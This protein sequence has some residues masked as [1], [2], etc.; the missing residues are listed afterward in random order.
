VSDQAVRVCR[1]GCN[2]APAIALVLQA[3]FAEYECLYTR[4]AFAATTPP[5]EEIVRRLGEGPTWIAL[6]HRT[7][8]GTVSAVLREEALYIRS[9]A[10]VPEARGRGVGRLLLEQVERYAGER[11][12][13]YLELSTT[14]FLTSAIALYE[15]AGFSQ[16]DGEPRQLCGTPLFNMRKVLVLHP[17][18]W[19]PASTQDLE[20]RSMPATK[21][22]FSLVTEHSAV[23]PAIANRHFVGKLAIE[24]DPSD[25]HSDLERGVN[26]FVVVDA[27]SPEDYARCHIPGAISLPHRSITGDAEAALPKDKLIVTYCWGPGCN[28]ANKA[29]ARLSAL[30]FQ[31][32]EMIG[33]IEYWRKVGYPIEGSSP[34]DAPLYG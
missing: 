20:V 31:V 25:V 27:R 24:T 32:K 23:A 22:A 16:N 28:A 29:A 19:S 14:P 18:R 6:L 5:T 33:G 8:V 15:R 3:A 17:Q 7:V 11:G 10:V 2:D 12:F 34:N 26:G 21:T 30:G 9:M 1:A 13:R 4:A